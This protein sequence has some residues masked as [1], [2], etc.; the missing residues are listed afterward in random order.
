MIIINEHHTVLW[1]FSNKHGMHISDTNI[2]HI[3]YHNIIIIYIVK[4]QTYTFVPVIILT[5]VAI[6]TSTMY[7]SMFDI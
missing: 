6:R 5:I 4:L 2:D 7:V 1:I 3:T